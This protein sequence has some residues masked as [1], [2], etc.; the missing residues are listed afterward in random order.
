M[1]HE[2]YSLMVIR[3]LAPVGTLEAPGAAEDEASHGDNVGPACVDL[4]F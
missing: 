1:N 4:L 2:S 3:Q